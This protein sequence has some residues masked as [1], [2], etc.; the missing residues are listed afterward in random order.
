MWARFKSVILKILLIWIF[1]LV[2]SLVINDIIEYTD[3]S[4]QDLIFLKWFVVIFFGSLSIFLI[5]HIISKSGSSSNQKKKHFNYKHATNNS[6]MTQV[7]S[8]KNL[9]TK[10]ESILDNYKKKSIKSDADKY[11]SIANKR[12]KTKSDRI[13]EKY[14]ETP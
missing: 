7:L 13:I 14:N 4:P 5:L 2:F 6:L 9:S 12:L 11:E 10:S 1:L 8:K 3:T